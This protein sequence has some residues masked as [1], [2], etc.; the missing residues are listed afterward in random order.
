M[1]KIVLIVSLLML[2]TIGFAAAKK[3]SGDRE[4]NKFLEQVSY[5]VHEGRVSRADLRSHIEQSF[6]V[7]DAD[8]KIMNRRGLEPG[9]K[10]L[11]GLIHKAT[12]TNVSTIS[13][14]Y[15]GRNSWKDVIYQCGANPDALEAIQK[16]DEKKWKKAVSK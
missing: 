2:P 5:D 13:N 1:R 11:V 12:N 6:G 10:Y 15:R 4:L 7:T 3:D 14:R 16:A 9:E 8:Y